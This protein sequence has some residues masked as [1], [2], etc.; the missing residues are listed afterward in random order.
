M[1]NQQQTR[2]SLCSRSML[3]GLMCVPFFLAGCSSSHGVDKGKTQ[4]VAK[5]NGEEVTVHEV[6]QYMSHLTQLDGTPEQMRKQAIDAVIDQHLLQTAAKQAKLDRDVNVVQA[7]LDS[8][9]NILIDAYKARQFHSGTAPTDQQIAAY[10]QSHPVLFSDRKL[11]QLQQLRVQS[12]AENQTSLLAQLKQSDNIDA[13]VHWLDAQHIP[14]DTSNTTKA[15]EDMSP[16]ER[17]LIM[18]IKVGEAA[19]LN[20]DQDSIS[21]DLLLATQPQPISLAH[22]QLR[23]RDLLIAESAAQ[24]VAL[25]LKQARLNSKIVYTDIAQ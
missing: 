16:S 23:I 20:Q 22:A 7:E 4:V 5:V 10:Y 12:S 13:F 8:K 1:K 3:L 25:W 2:F 17:S 14:Y 19:I 6:N 24:Q 11:Y 18:Q 21:I 9:K 15:P